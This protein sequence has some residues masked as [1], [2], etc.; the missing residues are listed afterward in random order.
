VRPATEALLPHLAQRRCIWEPAA[1]KGDMLAPLAR[2]SARVVASDIEPSFPAM[3]RGDFLDATWSIG[4]DFDAI[5]SQT[6]LT[7]SPRNSASRHAPS[8]SKGWSAICD[9]TQEI[10]DQLES[11]TSTL[12]READFNETRR[13]VLYELSVGGHS[14]DAGKAGF[15]SN[16]LLQSL[17]SAPLLSAEAKDKLCRV[18][19]MPITA[20][21]RK[22]RPFGI[23]GASA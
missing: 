20:N 13:V 12:M 7:T 19:H 16:T 4:A 8:L 10:P 18:G 9:Q 14:S 15:G 11:L 22:M 1:G 17:S 6:R 21:L 5:T 2:K 23:V 3:L